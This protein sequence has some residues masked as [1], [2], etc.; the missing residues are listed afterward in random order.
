M[1]PLFGLLLGLVLL[2]TGP[3][4]HAWSR[5]GHMVTGA[6]AHEDLLGSDARV[7]AQVADILEKHP[8]R[9]TFEVALGAATGEARTRRLFMEMARWPDDIRNSPFDHP[10]WHYSGKPLIDPREPP[11][12]AVRNHLSGAALEAFALNLRLAGDRNASAAERAV[13][14]CWI[15]HLVGDMHQPLHAVDLFSLRFP[16]GDRGGG[17]QFVRETAD[18]EP[19]TLHGFWDGIVP[20]TGEAS[21]VLDT[22]NALRARSTR[23]AF[24][25]LAARATTNIAVWSSESVDLAAAKVYRSDLRTGASPQN[26]TVLTPDYVSDARSTGELRIVLAGYRLSDLLRALFS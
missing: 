19:Q 20:G 25:Q 21:D 14:L 17:L 6:I 18:S 2:G 11:T 10:T 26:A 7:I 3:L 12:T 8:D 4:S 9:G 1:K 23:S 22:A 16:E 24:P 5:S 13:A 15:F